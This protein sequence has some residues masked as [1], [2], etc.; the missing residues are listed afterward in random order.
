MQKSEYIYTPLDYVKE[1]CMKTAE[2]A[3]LG[4]FVV[5]GLT[6][7]F[8]MTNCKIAGKKFLLRNSMIGWKEY[9]M[10]VGQE[11][12]VSVAFNSLFTTAMKKGD[13]PLTYTQRIF[14]SSAA[15]AI[16][17]ILDTPA[18][19]VAQT[20]QLMGKNTA[21]MQVV[22]EIWIKNGL[23]GL[24]RGNA[25]VMTREATWASVF[26]SVTPIVSEQCQIKVGVKKSY[27]DLMAAVSAGAIF[28]VISTPMKV[29]QFE[30]QNGLTQKKPK[31]SYVSI[32]K[33][34]SVNALFRGLGPRMFSTVVAAAAFTEGKKALETMKKSMSSQ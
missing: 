20:K 21:T 30:Q 23:S 28:G 13:E 12:A 24:W 7:V 17:G 31:E 22:K 6:P 8:N 18:D 26:L 16:A 9:V 2:G 25:M 34:T 27:A 5:S 32:I 19:T 11:T 15:G 1:F 4:T 10:A 33:R 3:T 29:L 14:A